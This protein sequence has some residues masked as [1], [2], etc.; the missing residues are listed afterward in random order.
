V[1]GEILEGRGIE[2]PEKR[3]TC[4]RVKYTAKKGTRRIRNKNS[5][6]Q[7]KALV[8]NHLTQRRQDY[9]ES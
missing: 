9:K 8:R 5:Q 4:S 6:Q 3:K 2:K 1:A 7:S